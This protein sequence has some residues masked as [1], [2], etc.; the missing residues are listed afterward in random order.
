MKKPVAIC[1]L[2]VLLATLL[3][4]CAG[5]VPEE[6]T[7][8]TYHPNVWGQPEDFGDPADWERPEEWDDDIAVLSA[9][10]GYDISC[11]YCV[12]NQLRWLEGKE[13][14]PHVE[15]ATAEKFIYRGETEQWGPFEE[16]LVHVTTPDGT[17]FYLRVLKDD[18]L[19]TI[20]QEGLE[21][22]NIVYMCIE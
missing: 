5:D 8:E 12:V 19:Y 18:V 22:K 2:F 9:L 1:L 7:S 20:W 13:L 11:A 6:S 21:E 16:E 17:D 14:A 4:G 10:E 15:I 3:C